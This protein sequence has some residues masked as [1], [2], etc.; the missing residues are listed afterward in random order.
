[1]I[2]RLCI[3]CFSCGQVRV[4]VDDTMAASWLSHV[5]ARTLMQQLR[6][7]LLMQPPSWQAP[8]RCFWFAHS[9]GLDIILDSRLWA[10]TRVPLAALLLVAYD[11]VLTGQPAQ[12][13]A[14]SR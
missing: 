11:G 6:L 9:V 10:T 5:Q 1:M 13:K 4:S 2:D 3:S 8:E 7:R 12:N 14:I